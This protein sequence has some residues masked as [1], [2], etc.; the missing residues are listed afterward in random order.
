MLTPGSTHF[1]TITK[2]AEK[3]IRLA[4]SAAEMDEV[5]VAAV[6]I[7]NGKVL[8]AGVNRIS[9]FKDPTAHAELIAIKRAAKR[10]NNE[11]LLDCELITTLEP[12]SMCTGAAVLARVK[13]IYYCA[14]ESKY[15]GSEKILSNFQ[16]N[17]KPELVQLDHLQ[18][19]AAELL[20]GF[21]SK[22]RKK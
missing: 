10:L 16:F 9:R 15:A 6:I 4:K 18:P 21:F 7:Q 14:A 11:R 13:R 20:T 22:R 12:C 5:P 1:K 19:V 17:H 2:F 8:A 3:A